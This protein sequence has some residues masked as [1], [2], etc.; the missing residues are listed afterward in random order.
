LVERATAW[1]TWTTDLLACDRRGGDGWVSVKVENDQE[2]FVDI[3]RIARY[4][5]QTLSGFHPGLDVLV[6]KGL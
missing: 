5:M 3:P 1:G 6:G 4:L 2:R